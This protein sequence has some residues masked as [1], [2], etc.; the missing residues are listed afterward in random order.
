MS[1]HTF[2]YFGTLESESALYT[3]A[4]PV[5]IDALAERFHVEP[6][7]VKMV[8]KKL[9]R[10]HRHRHFIAYFEEDEHQAVQEVIAKSG[11]LVNDV[12]GDR[13]L[14]ED[15]PNR[16]RIIIDLKPM[17]ALPNDTVNQVTEKPRSVVP[18]AGTRAGDPIRVR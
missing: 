11:R 3:S 8:A 17:K 1:Q 16:Y 14:V 13:Y 15:I 5:I 4:Q 10:F 12:L 7:K 2:R 6:I 18:T 9:T